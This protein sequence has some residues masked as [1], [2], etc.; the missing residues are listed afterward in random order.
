MIANLEH[1]MGIN[2]VWVNYGL[3]WV[4]KY[5][6]DFAFSLNFEPPGGEEDSPTLQVD[7]KEE[8]KKG[9]REGDKGGVEEEGWS[10]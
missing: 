4:P 5:Q 1:G 9:R 8:K 7:G 6:L 10:G 2:L 3:I